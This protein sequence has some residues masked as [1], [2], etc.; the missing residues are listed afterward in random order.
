MAERIGKSAELDQACR[1][2]ILRSAPAIPDGSL[3]FVNVSPYALTHAS[4]SANG[5]AAEFASAGLPVDRVVLEITERSTVSVSLVERAV[6]DLR[7]AGFKIALDDVG[8][9]SAGFEMLRR[10]PVE[11]VKLDRAA[12]ARA[13]ADPLGRAAVIAIAAFSAQAGA[14]VVA[15]GI[16]DARMMELV[17]WIAAGGDEPGDSMVYAVQG[18]LLGKPAPEVSAGEPP[19]QLAA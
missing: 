11:F 4:F 6:K 19:A 13:L 12:L 5:L 18:F 2:A 17:R 15:E 10:V 9:G 7:T 3:L 16:E 1:A 8:S 14:L